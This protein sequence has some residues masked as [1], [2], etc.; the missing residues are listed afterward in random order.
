MASQQITL[1]QKALNTFTAKQEQYLPSYLVPCYVG[2]RHFCFSKS[3]YILSIRSNSCLD[4]PPRKLFWHACLQIQPLFVVSMSKGHG[5]K[6]INI[7]DLHMPVNLHRQL[8]KCS[9][10][11]SHFCQVGQTVASHAKS[12]R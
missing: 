11:C 9:G 12:G 8:L 6:F 10:S 4:K 7:K 3:P 5:R 1:F 2:G